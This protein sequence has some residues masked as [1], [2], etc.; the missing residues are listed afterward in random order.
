MS[1]QVAIFLD[2][3]KVR[4]AAASR[5]HLSDLADR[6]ST[7]PSPLSLYLVSSMPRT[8]APRSVPFSANPPLSSRSVVARLVSG[9]G[10]IASRLRP[11]ERES[12]VKP[13]VCDD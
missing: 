9:W 10:D 1:E 8:L 5:D 13:P 6:H 3:A 2:R 4:R 7:C 11:V 12:E